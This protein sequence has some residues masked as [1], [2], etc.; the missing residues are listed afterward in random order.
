MHELNQPLISNFAKFFKYLLK[1]LT[2]PSQPHS[3]LSMK[4]F[5]SEALV[6]LRNRKKRKTLIFL[7]LKYL[8]NKQVRTE[9]SLPILVWPHVDTPCRLFS[10]SI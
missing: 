9:K 6:S 10:A 8:K 3:K 2:I 5:F 4:P 7:F 1:I